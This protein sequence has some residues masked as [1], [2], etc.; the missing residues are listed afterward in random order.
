MFEG[1]WLQGQIRGRQKRRQGRKK[2]RGLVEKE[3]WS[4][5]NL[6]RYQQAMRRVRGER[7]AEELR[8]KEEESSQQ[9]DFFWVGWVGGHWSGFPSSIG[10]L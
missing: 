5:P 7:E 3:K 2:E 4:V 8:A 9:V 10:D 1:Q 6:A